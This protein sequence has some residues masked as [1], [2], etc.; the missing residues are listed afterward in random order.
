[1]PEKDVTTLL[2]AWG[3]GDRAAGDDLF[4][5][6]YDELRRIAQRKPGVSSDATLQPTALINEAFLRLTHSL[7]TDWR[8]RTQ[9]FA[10]AAVVMRNIMLDYS[11]RKKT[12]KRGDV[13]N[14]VSLD[15]ALY[16][17]DGRELDVEAL[18]DAL[19]RLAELDE[20]Q[21]KI[22]ELRFFGGMSVQ[23]DSR[24]PEHLSANRKPGMGHGQNVA[25]GAA[26]SEAVNFPSR[27]E[28]GASRRVLACNGWKDLCA[29][30]D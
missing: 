3:D 26:W 25:G 7:K 23:E 16:S 2:R 30:T 9:F 29:W 14:W 12:G 27:A 8:D 21:A 11:R 17:T 4:P 1:M 13:E 6:I 5:V 10:Y 28:F 19:T 18:D 20:T 15:E 22:V 24:L